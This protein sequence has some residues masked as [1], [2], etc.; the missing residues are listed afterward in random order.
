MTMKS[1]KVGI[2][3][4]QD[5]SWVYNQLRFS[6]KTEA[7]AYASDLFMRWTAVTKYIVEPSEDEVNATFPNPSDRYHTERGPPS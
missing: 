4:K 2:K 1:Y 5:R 3:T 7:E 6:T